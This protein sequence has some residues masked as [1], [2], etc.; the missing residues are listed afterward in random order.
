MRKPT[1]IT[2]ANGVTLALRFAGDAFLGVG[3]TGEEYRP[4]RP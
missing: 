1:R 4:G 2:L 3:R